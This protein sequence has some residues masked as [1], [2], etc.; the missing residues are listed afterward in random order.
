MM[1][2]KSWTKKRT[3]GCNGKLEPL[4]ARIGVVWMAEKKLM[5]RRTLWEKM[6]KNY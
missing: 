1:E 6:G 3:I 2:K 5:A 4:V